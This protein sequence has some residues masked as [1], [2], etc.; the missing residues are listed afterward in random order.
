VAGAAWKVARV[1]TSER[2]KN[3]PPPFIT[4]Q[5]QQAAARRLSFAVRRTMQIAQR[6]YEGRE[7]PGRG[8]LGL[9]TYMRTDS[10]RVSDDATSAEIEA[11][12]AVYRASGS[13]LKSAGYLAVYGVAAEEEEEGEGAAGKSGPRGAGEGV[14]PPLSEGETVKLLSVTPEKKETQPPPR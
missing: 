7:I 2:R 5:L 14:L 11:G 10:T 12:R 3:P 8:T 9:I 4:S 13:T 6:L 1:E